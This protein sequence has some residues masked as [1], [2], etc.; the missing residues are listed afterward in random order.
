MKHQHVTHIL[1]LNIP[2]KYHVESGG[3][4][5]RNQE[6]W[7]GLVTFKGDYFEVYKYFRDRPKAY[8]GDSYNVSEFNN[9]IYEDGDL[10]WKGGSFS[11]LMSD[12]RDFT[13]Y[14]Q[15]R[16]K[17]SQ[18]K[19]WEKI[20]HKFNEASARKRKRNAYDG[21]YDHDKRW[22]SEPFSKREQAKTTTRIVKLKVEA[23]FSCMVP[24]HVIAEFSA[25]IA[26]VVNMLEQNG[27]LCEIIAC[28]TGRGFANYS[29]GSTLYHME[30]M[31]KEAD[32]YLPVQ[33]I[34]K[35]FS[36]NWYRRISF[37]LIVAASEMLGATVDSG[38]GSPYSFGK[39]WDSS[40]D[41]LNIYSVPD[42]EQQNNILEHLL[43]HFS[44]DEEKKKI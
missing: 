3:R 35:V 40:G 5:G 25:F 34:M 7:S 36:P 33:N 22:D 10:G 32:E 41:T 27:V 30:L 23:G 21:E 42:Y 2:G 26:A 24:A 4:F 28:K 17:L 14:D 38:L 15:V 8:I 39:C 31:V 29:G 18:N 43:K 37:G 1:G 12:D 16:G 13:I 6:A 44:E 19:V 20:V 11:E 9:Q